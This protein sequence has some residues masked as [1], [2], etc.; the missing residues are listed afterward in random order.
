MQASLVSEVRACREEA[1]L[2]SNEAKQEW[3]AAREH[4]EEQL[5]KGD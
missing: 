4:F 5:L 1:Q 2:L 3:E